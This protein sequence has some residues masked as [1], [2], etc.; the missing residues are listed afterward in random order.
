[1]ADL[2]KKYT[3]YSCHTK[4][5]DLGKPEPLCPKCG[6]DQRDADDKPVATSSRK[7]RVA[8]PPPPVIEEPE[9]EAEAEAE[10]AVA[11]GEGDEDEEVV[12]PVD[13]REEEAEEEEEDY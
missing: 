7:G 4:F 5:Y 8:A 12:A 13:G 10:P 9:F 1:M 11:A 3:C 6:A 2:G